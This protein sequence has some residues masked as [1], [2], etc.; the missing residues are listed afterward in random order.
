MGGLGSDFAA[1]GGGSPASRLPGFDRYRA[2]GQIELLKGSEWYLKG[3]EFD[4]QRIT[5]GWNK[6]LSAA[7]ARGHDG[8]G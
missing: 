3:D 4:L 8:I 1:A 7:L 2:A 6:K 5:G